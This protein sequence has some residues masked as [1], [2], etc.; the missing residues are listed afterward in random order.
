MYVCACMHLHV[1]TH[2]GG[3]H[4]NGHVFAHTYV[5]TSVWSVCDCRSVSVWLVCVSTCLGPCLCAWVFL[6]VHIMCV[7]V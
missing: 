7:N 4:I 1:C 3:S 6:F 5:C 2:A